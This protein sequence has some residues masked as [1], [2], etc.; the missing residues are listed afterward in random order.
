MFKDKK[1]ETS[2]IPSFIRDKSHMLSFLKEFNNLPIEII[3]LKENENA[4]LELKLE[5]INSI[6]VFI[7][8][9]N[10][11]LFLKSYPKG[12]SV[13]G[14]EFI[15]KENAKLV[16]ANIKEK[17]GKCINYQHAE[18]YDNSKMES[19]FFWHGTGRRNSQITLYG[20]KTY[21]YGADMIVSSKKEKV[22]MKFNGKIIGKNAMLEEKIN[23][24]AHDRSEFDIFG[25][26]SSEKTSDKSNGRL[27]ENFLVLGN[28]I[29][30]NA[31]PALEANGDSAK[32]EHS[33]SI[34]KLDKNKIF[35]LQT[36]GIAEKNAKELMVAAFMHSALEKIDDV[37]VR[38]MYIPFE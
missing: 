20:D 16:F 8:E 32:T 27:S 36:K 4:E 19:L 5:D 2:S 15:L 10:S 38:E 29:K 23:V 30:I 37:R 9:K 35:Y 17:C 13:V 33:A 25:D 11:N 28:K 12:N 21:F 31:Q 3:K 14:F 18:L 7:L 24:V 34:S 22:S 26:I 1:S 6:Y